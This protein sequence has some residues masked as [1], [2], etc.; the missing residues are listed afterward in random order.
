MAKYLPRCRFA[1]VP[2]LNGRYNDE[3]SYLNSIQPVG[4]LLL[5]FFHDLL[6][7]MNLLIPETTQGGGHVYVCTPVSVASCA[8]LL[9]CALLCTGAQLM[10]STSLLEWYIATDDHAVLCSCSLR[11]CSVELTEG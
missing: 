3:S 6:L 1:I 10:L 11:S 2:Q 4:T 7:S 5:L 8:L 9:C